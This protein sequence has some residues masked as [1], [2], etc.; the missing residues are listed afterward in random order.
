[1]E[2]AKRSKSKPVTKKR[3][4]LEDIIKEIVDK[5]ASWNCSLTIRINK[6]SEF[7]MVNIE[8]CTE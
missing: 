8:Y 4:V 7:I 3:P 5:Y 2:S 6:L 1:M